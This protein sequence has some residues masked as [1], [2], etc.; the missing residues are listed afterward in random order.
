MNAKDT[1]TIGLLQTHSVTQQCNQ[2]WGVV[3]WSVRSS[4]APREGGP[5]HQTLA[6]QYTHIHNK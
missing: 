4:S 5:A 2:S 1:A 3:G 6:E